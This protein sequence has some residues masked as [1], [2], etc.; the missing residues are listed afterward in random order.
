MVHHDP[1]VARLPIS[2]TGAQRVER[3]VLDTPPLPPYGGCEPE[4]TQVTPKARKLT[5]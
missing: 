2:G 4:E 1:S 3:S 5:S